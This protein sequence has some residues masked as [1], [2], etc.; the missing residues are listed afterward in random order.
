M[1]VLLIDD[2]RTMRGLQ[3]LV[4]A[5]LGFTQVLEVGDGVEALER[6]GMFKPDLIICDWNS[7]RS[8]GLNFVK[9]FRLQDAVT[10]IIM[11]TSEASRSCISEALRAGVNSY[12]V[13]PF[14]PDL[15]SQR[16]YETTARMSTQV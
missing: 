13:K 8:N 7:P 6:V 4:L 14:T 3:K 9:T 16:I 12:V 10:P 2:S 1:R 5:Q 15:L 11:C